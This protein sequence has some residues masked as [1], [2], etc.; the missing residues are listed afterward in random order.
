MV[1]VD[2]KLNCGVLMFYWPCQK[3]VSGFRKE[4]FRNLGHSRSLIK[5]VEKRFYWFHTYLHTR[6]QSFFGAYNKYNIDI[7]NWK[8]NIYVHH[9]SR[10]DVI[11]CSGE[12]VLSVGPHRVPALL[13]AGEVHEVAGSVHL[14]VELL[15]VGQRQ[16][17]PHV[18]VVA[19]THEV[20]VPGALKGKNIV[21][22]H[23]IH[24]TLRSN[25]RP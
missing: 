7:M 14:V 4:I 16:L 22:K 20:V 18:G 10:L 15:G 3:R 17:V 23:S 12:H 6:L 8:Q 11:K 25:L 1:S 9:G 13:D 5:Q 24:Q 19:D 21:I 2:P